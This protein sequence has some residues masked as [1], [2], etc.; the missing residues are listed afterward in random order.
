MPASGAQRHRWRQG[1]HQR[2]VH[3]QD[4]LTRRGGV[5]WENK[6]FTLTP[7]RPRDGSRGRCFFLNLT[8]DK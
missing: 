7:R 4:L 1:S 6:A 3:R 2:L 5:V 8:S